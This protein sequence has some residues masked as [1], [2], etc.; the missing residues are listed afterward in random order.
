MVNRE[1][2]CCFEENSRILIALSD[3]IFNP[4]SN[5]KVDEKALKCKEKNILVKLKTDSNSE[6][7]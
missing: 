3:V 2:S 1:I 4:S 5:D 6:K 7:K